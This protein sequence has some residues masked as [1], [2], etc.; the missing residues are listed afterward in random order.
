MINPQEA[1]HL[2][3]SQSFDFRVRVEAFLLEWQPEQPGF[4]LILSELSRVTIGFFQQQQD[5]HLQQVFAIIEKLLVEGDQVVRD[6]AATCFLENILHRVPEEVSAQ[7]FLSFLG[8]KS[9]EYC[10]A[11]NDFTGVQLDG[12]D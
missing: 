7:T 9:K 8:L 11:Y 6:A 2:L 3:V 5:T 1:L 4:C 10:K 12:F